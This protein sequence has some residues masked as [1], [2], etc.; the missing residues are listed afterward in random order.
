MSMR[1]SIGST[2]SDPKVDL[3]CWDPSDASSINE[4]IVERGKPGPLFTDVALRVR[5]MLSCFTVAD[6]ALSGFLGPEYE[7]LH[8]SAVVRVDQAQE[9]A[10]DRILGLRL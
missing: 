7:V 9:V 8:M 1:A 6:P 5:T 10:T 4:S 2:A 3:H